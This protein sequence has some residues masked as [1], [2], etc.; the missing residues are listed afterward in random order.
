MSEDIAKEAECCPRCESRSIACLGYEIN[1][2]RV[3]FLRPLEYFCHECGLIWLNFTWQ[4]LRGTDSKAVDRAAM[5]W[6]DYR[7]EREQ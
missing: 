6:E 1:P 7:K 2:E 4:Q 5:E 3:R